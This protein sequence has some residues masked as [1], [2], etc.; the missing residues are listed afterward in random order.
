M[1][2]KLKHFDDC[3][4]THLHST[5]DMVAQTPEGLKILVD[6]RSALPGEILSANTG[7]RK[8]KGLYEARDI[9]VTQP[10]P[11]RQK[12]FCR[13]FGYCGGC[14]WQLAPY[15]TQVHWKHDQLIKWITHALPGIDL[16][17]EEPLASPQWTEYRNKMEYSF[18]ARRWRT[19]EEMD[20][21]NNEDEVS[22]N[23]ALGL[24]VPGTPGKVLDI[25]DCSL[26][27]SLGNELR[28]GLREFAQA[29]GLEFF[30]SRKCTG[31]LRTLVIRNSTQ[32]QWLVMIITAYEDPNREEQLRT[33]CQTQFPWITSFYFM[34]N[35]KP[36]DSYQDCIPRHQYGQEWI[37][38]TLDGLEFHIGPLSFF[39]TNLYQTP[40]LYQLVQEYA[41]IEPHHLVY[42]LYTGTGTIAAY[43]ARKALKVIG[44][45][46]VEEATKAA[47]RACRENGLENTEFYAGDMKDLLTLDFFQS[48]GKPD[49]V[50][51]DPPRAGIHPQVI[52]NIIAVGPERIVYVSCNP[53][54]LARDLAVFHRAYDITRLRSIDMAPQTP[55]GEAVAQLTRRV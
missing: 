28:N 20:L 26:Q 54:S 5:G 29:Q 31:Y 48:H 52:E 36:N 30:E 25:Y 12:P 19:P 47:T 44:I 16:P 50:V 10:V 4:V 24:F 35:P 1:A 7:T 34:T 11:L 17:I 45:E 22:N 23:Q 6:G 8:R 53:Q 32:D 18:S 14:R 37:T 9:Q 55:H 41:Q 3:T 38:E 42:D 15:E 51:C 2:K 43:L 40:R 39:Q 27:N 21:P 46:Y 33:Y 49:V 13:H